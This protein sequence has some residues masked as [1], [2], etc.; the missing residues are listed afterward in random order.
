MRVCASLASLILLTA[1]CT[2]A[3]QPTLELATTTSV[4]NSGLLD[5]LIAE[6]QAE[7]GITL[8]IH[9][10]GSGR[11]LAMLAD[12]LV[13]AVISHA[14][15]TERRFLAQHANWRYRKLASNR[16]ILVGPAADAAGVREATDAVAAFERIARSG[17]PF[18]SRGDGSGTHEREQSLWEAAG[19]S[20]QPPQLLVSGRGMAM[21]LRHADER[22]AYTLSDDATFFQLAPQL[23]LVELFAADPRLLNT[24]AIVAPPGDAASALMEWLTRGRGREHIA[25]FAIGGRRAFAVWPGACR[26]DE[27]AALPCR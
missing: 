6:Y 20:V 21:A 3:R 13:D 14:P 2:P 22:Q 9:A 16:F 27:P 15:E 18:V 10:A 1:A 4:Q 26:D 5:R 17:A 8:R 19:V 7:T 23:S 12:G 25:A 11:A 24:Y